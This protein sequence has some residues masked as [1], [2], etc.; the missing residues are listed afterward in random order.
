MMAW[1]WEAE[2]IDSDKDDSRAWVPVSAIAPANE[3]NR[4]MPQ[5]GAEAG[6]AI[7]EG[8]KAILAGLMYPDTK[9]WMVSSRTRHP[10][11]WSGR[12]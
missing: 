12:Q 5:E 1:D 3:A 2:D 10:Y 4:V 7:G 6:E 11:K 9:V 8:H